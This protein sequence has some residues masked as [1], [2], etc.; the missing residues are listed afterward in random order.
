M[1]LKVLLCVC[2]KLFNLSQSTFWRLLSQC[3][4][5]YFIHLTFRRAYKSLLTVDTVQIHL[6]KSLTPVCVFA[7]K[8]L[9]I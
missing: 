8:T 3:I 1:M 5:I 7:L 6:N 9:M 4:R 2:I